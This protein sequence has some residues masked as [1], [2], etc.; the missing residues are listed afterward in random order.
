VDCETADVIDAAI[1][2]CDDI[3]RLARMSATELG[4]HGHGL[5]EVEEMA[6]AIHE[7]L[8]QDAGPL[9]GGG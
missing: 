5:E 7:H 6:Q 4:P 2:A 3:V 9:A 1:A 8:A